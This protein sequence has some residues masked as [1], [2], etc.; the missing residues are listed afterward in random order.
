MI[1]LVITRGVA[2]PQATLAMAWGVTPNSYVDYSHSSHYLALFDT[3]NFIEEQLDY[4]VTKSLLHHKS[5]V[6][7]KQRSH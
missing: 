5:C 1:P 4:R 3:N 2:R 7:I 6:N